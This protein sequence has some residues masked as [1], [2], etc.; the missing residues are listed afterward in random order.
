MNTTSVP[1]SVYAVA[2]LGCRDQL[3]V[4]VF[5][6]GFYN[7]GTYRGQKTGAF[8]RVDLDRIFYQKLDLPLE[9]Q[10]VATLREGGLPLEQVPDGMHCPRCREPLGLSESDLSRMLPARESAVEAVVL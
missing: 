9:L 1:A 5:H 10:R 8:Y 4:P 2:C 6:G 7:F 3:A